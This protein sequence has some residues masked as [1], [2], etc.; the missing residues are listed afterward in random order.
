MGLGH[1]W[2]M[3]LGHPLGYWVYLTVRAT[4]YTSPCG[5]L[6]Y[7]TTRGLL[8]YATI[9]GLLGILHPPWATGTIRRGLRVLSAVGYGDC[10]S[11]E[12]HPAIYR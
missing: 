8:G 4:G 5:L 11:C 3:G 6:G 2:A 10:L 1:P 12:R 9:R 7:A